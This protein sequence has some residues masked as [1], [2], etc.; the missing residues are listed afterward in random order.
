MSVE[1]VTPNFSQPDVNEV[2]IA[3][4]TLADAVESGEVPV[5]SAL[6]VTLVDGCADVT[7]IGRNLPI[8][9]AIG[10]LELAKA[11]IIQGAWK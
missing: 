10:L 9:E 7:C 4:R 3:A 2:V 1:L 11:K 5:E 8:S 6:I